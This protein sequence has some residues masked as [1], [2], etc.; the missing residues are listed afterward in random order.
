LQFE[1]KSGQEFWVFGKD[2]GKFFGEDWGR[3]VQPEAEETTKYAARRSQNQR[4]E[5]TNQTNPTNAV[6]EAEKHQ[7]HKE[8]QGL[9]KGIA[10]TR[11]CEDTKS[12][13][14]GRPQSAQAENSEGSQYER[15]E[16]GSHG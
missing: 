13:V 9:K 8:H 11:K 15:G 1:A 5:T 2:F 4:V 6:R 16:G 14:N 7:G 12:D 3:G 10:K